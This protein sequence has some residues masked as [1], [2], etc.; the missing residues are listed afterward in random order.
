MKGKRNDFRSVSLLFAYYF[1]PFQPLKIT[2]HHFARLPDFSIS[3]MIVSP[4]QSTESKCANINP[5][6][7]IPGYTAYYFQNGKVCKKRF[8]CD[9][10]W[11]LVAAHIIGQPNCISSFTEFYIECINSTWFIDIDDKPFGQIDQA[12]CYTNNE[13]NRLSN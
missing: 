4:I 3:N 1:S 7:I 10:M 2:M 11:G 6:G 5:S 9:G 8:V 12:F 13:S